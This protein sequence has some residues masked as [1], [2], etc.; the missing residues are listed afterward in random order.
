MRKTQTKVMVLMPLR[1][2]LLLVIAVIVLRGYSAAAEVVGVDNPQAAMSQSVTMLDPFELIDVTVTTMT[3]PLDDDWW[4]HHHRHRILR[5]P[6]KPP[7]P[8]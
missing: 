5:S 8:W 2:I 7:P 6:Y 1:L 4:R 3:E